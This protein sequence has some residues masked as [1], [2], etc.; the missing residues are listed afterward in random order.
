MQFVMTGPASSQF[1]DISHALITD[2]ETSGGTCKRLIG[3][4]RFENADASADHIVLGIGITVA[5]VDAFIAGALPD[6][7]T[8]LRQDWY[9]WRA[10][11]WHPGPT[12]AS[13]ANNFI[14]IPIDIRSGRR[15]REGFRLIAIIEKEITTE[16]AWNMVL[17]LRSLWTLQA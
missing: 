5:T 12:A 4:L 9:Y 8:D 3:D 17:S 15:L 11:A 2:G 6:P 13:N 1:V 7:L 10:S 16:V 14:T